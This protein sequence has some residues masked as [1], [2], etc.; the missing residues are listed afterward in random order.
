M[1]KFLTTLIASLTLTVPVMAQSNHDDHFE[2]WTTLQKAGVI[3]RLNTFECFRRSG[4]IDGYYLSNTRTLVICQ[5]DA[6]KIGQQMPWSEN[7]YDTLRHEAMHV[8]QDCNKGIIGDGRLSVLFDDKEEYKKF[9]KSKLTDA[10]I[11]NILR[12]YDDIS[13]ERQLLEIEAF[14]VARGVDVTHITTAVN[15]VCGNDL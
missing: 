8:I 14:A 2:L 1:K 5:P 7:D 12:W 11:N 9:V 4:E 3:T 10:Q 6:N 15:K 13:E